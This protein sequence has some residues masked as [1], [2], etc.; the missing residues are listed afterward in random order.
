MSANLRTSSPRPAPAGAQEIFDTTTVC[1]MVLPFEHGLEPKARTLE[2]FHALGVAF[3]SLTV[4]VDWDSVEDV[5]RV[6]AEERDRARL[7]SSWLTLATT[8]EDI[9]R[10]R[11]DH[12]LAVGFNFQGTNPLMGSSELVELY[13]SLG[14]RQMLLVYNKRN[15]VGSGSHDEIDE[16][17]TE[18]GRRAIAAMNRNGVIVDCS[19]TGYRTSLDAVDASSAPVVF[20]HS[21][22][23]AL[24]PHPRNIRDDQIRACARSGGVVGINGVGMF[25][26]PNTAS[27]Q[28]MARHI[29]HM[30]QL[31]GAEHVGIG[32]DLVYFEE[33]MVRLFRAKRETFPSGYPEPPWEFVQPEQLPLLVDELLRLGYPTASI[34]AIFGGNF[35]RVA[36]SIWQEPGPDAQT[37]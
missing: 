15:A 7:N 17:L 16:G 8:V 31:V 34:Q 4:A 18:F 35:L 5:L 36:K 14:V 3:A 21:N 24:H 2:R 12:R 25:L 28:L 23:W 26:S 9:E 22:A 20:S 6:L 30:V 13:A 29:D 19:H 1:D 27:V 37:V 10:A 32:L 33:I 11:R